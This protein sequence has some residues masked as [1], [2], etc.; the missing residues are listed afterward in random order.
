MDDA[1]VQQTAAAFGIDA[2]KVSHRRCGMGLIHPSWIVE[3][4]EG[5]CLLQRIN[6][7]VFP[8]PV[9]VAENAAAAAKRVDQELARRGDSDPRHRLVFLTADDRPWHRDD[10]GQVWRASV[11][12]P[13]SRPPDPSRSH[14]VRSAARA[15]GRFPGLV[16]GDHGGEDGLV[17]RGFHDTA[18]RISVLRTVAEQD[19]V[20]RLKGC[21]AECERLLELAALADR[22]P[23]DDGRRRL[24][25]NDAKLDNVLVDS[26]SGEALCVVDLD[27]VM[28]GLAA[29]DFGDLVRSAVSGRPEDEPDLERIAV[30]NAVFRDLAAGYLEGSAGWLSVAERSLLVDGAVVLTYEQAVRFLA[31]YLDGDRYFLI[32]DEQH[33]LRRTLAQLRLLEDLL[34]R[35]GELREVVDLLGPQT[36]EDGP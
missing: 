34:D 18:A 33:N 5:A 13:G 10:H 1:G 26:D 19:S 24:V 36:G 7:R 17:L 29:H 28:P 11:W 14:E 32:D 27:T 9:R 23:D 21:R 4:S 2:R 15:L 30:Q 31:D 35:E 6:A 3:S 22:L 8:D 12:V 16:A 25:H 20:D